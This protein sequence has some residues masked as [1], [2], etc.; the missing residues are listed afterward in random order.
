MIDSG[1]SVT[2]TDLTA[3][4]AIGEIYIPGGTNKVY[5]YI[6]YVAGAGVIAAVAGNVV[7]YY[8]PSGDFAAEGY[9]LGKVTSDVSDAL[10][11]A[12]VLQ[13]VIAANSYGWIQ[14]RG[15]A[16]LTT[17]PVSGADGQTL[18][19][20]TTTDGTVK[21]AAAVTDV[22]GMIAQDVSDKTVILMCP[23]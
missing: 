13:A 23:I 21:V 4:F 18:V 8:A 9:T 22:C 7:G 11:C 1:V 15:P 12:G 17:A 20:S 10:V 16:T 14:I 19:L 6:Q 5:K 2:Q 3:Q